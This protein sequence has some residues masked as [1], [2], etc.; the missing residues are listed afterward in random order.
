MLGT[1][2]RHSSLTGTFGNA[3]IGGI[4]ISLHTP[5]PFS[6]N[7]T[8]LQKEGAC[9]L[10]RL[11]KGA[12]ASAPGKPCSALSLTTALPR[13]N[14]QKVMKTP[15]S[16]ACSRSNSTVTSFEQNRSAEY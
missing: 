6:V 11:W 14:D 7:P 12:K 1:A 15:V 13:S 4:I 5:F 8:V 3:E 10:H 16:P 9:S 2:S